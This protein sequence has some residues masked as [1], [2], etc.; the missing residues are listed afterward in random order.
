LHG[1]P[2]IVTK[3]E[4]LYSIERKSQKR[5][6]QKENK[7]RVTV[8]PTPTWITSS[9]RELGGGLEV[10]FIYIIIEDTCCYGC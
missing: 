6:E 4:S 2:S 5:D 3:E 1:G 7:K 9:M 8:P 10:G